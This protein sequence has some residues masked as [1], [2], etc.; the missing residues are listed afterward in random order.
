MIGATE[1]ARAGAVRLTKECT[2]KELILHRTLL[3]A[4]ERHADKIAFHDGDYHATFAHHGDRVLRLADAMRHQLGLSGEDRF[5]VM[6]ANSH[7][8]LELYHAGFLGAG[9]INPLNLRLAGQELQFILADSGAKVVFV[10][11]LF[12]EHLV[13]NLGDARGDL[14]LEHIVLLD[15]GDV[16]HDIGYEDLIAAGHPVVPAEPDEDDPAMLMYTGGTTGVPKG[17][18][19]DHR[20][21]LLNLYHIGIDIHFNEHRVYLHQTPMFHAA[22]MG[23]VLGIP[24]TGATSVFVPLFDPPAVI[25]AIDRYQVN[26]TTMVPTMVA[27]VLDHPSFRPERLRSLADLTYGASPMPTALL[28][29]I[30]R[31]LPDARLWQGYGMTECSSLLTVLTPDDHAR[32]GGILRS[33]GRP[34]F[35]VNLAI[36]DEHD[37]VLPAGT[38]GEVCARGGNFMRGYWHRPETTAD[39]FTGDW[40]HTGDEGY[41]DEDGYLYLVDRVKDMIISGGENV[42]SIEVENAIAS[43]PDVAQVAVIGI[44][45]PVWGEQVHAIVVPRPGTTPTAEDITAHARRTLAGYKTPKSVEFRTEPLPLS[46]ALKPLKRDLRRPYWAHEPVEVS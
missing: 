31:E 13:R 32:G 6:A 45:H 9:I 37:R 36:H 1:T 16:P 21:E 43:H 14:P 30:R 27:M 28:E 40:Y 12:A 34:V 5:A 22:S 29:R 24:A 42:Y 39:T 18:L 25:D 17:V 26:W 3:P 15:D 46:G 19:L 20:A 10:D 41:L 4:I 7:Q 33:A 11:R 23:G 2:M 35:G 44:P 38:T 8:F